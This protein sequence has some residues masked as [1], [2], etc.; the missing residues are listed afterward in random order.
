MTQIIFTASNDVKESR[1]EISIG[2]PNSIFSGRTAHEGFV[3][4]RGGLSLREEVLSL[5]EEVSGGAHSVT[6]AFE[7]ELGRSSV[8]RFAGS[9]IKPPDPG[10]ARPNGR[11]PLATF[12]H[13]FGVRTGLFSSRRFAPRH[14]VA[15]A[16]G[17]DE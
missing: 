8:A 10:V 2:A 17:S 3:V 5:R 14:S 16:R 1:F 6:E 15:T 11:L 7:I 4:A 12:F 13:A 9:G